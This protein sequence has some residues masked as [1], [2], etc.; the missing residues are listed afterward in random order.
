MNIG[1]H[2]H[3]H[4]Y[5]RSVKGFW[6]R[7]AILLWSWLRVQQAMGCR[8]VLSELS[9]WRTRPFWSQSCR[10]AWNWEL[11][12]ATLQTSWFAML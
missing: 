6:P 4:S 3:W 8:T 10:R 1:T 9:S 5:G 7:Q 12:P 2:R 11:F